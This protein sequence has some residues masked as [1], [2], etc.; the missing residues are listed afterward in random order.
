MAR[1]TITEEQVLLRMKS[2]WS[3]NQRIAKS[4]FVIENTDLEMTKSQV[5]KILKIL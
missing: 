5:V 2:Q 3:D 1:D 4:D